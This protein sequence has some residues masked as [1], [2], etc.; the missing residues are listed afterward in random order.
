MLENLKF[1]G[2]YIGM[3]DADPR[4]IL[5][6]LIHIALGF[7]GIV[8]L[9]MILSSGFAFMVSGGDEEKISSAKKTLVNAIIGVLIMLSAYSIVNFVLNTLTTANS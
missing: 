6:R 3:S 7:V 1:F 8:L 9:L 5:A 4:L 2:S